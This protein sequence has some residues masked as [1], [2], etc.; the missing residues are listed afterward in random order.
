MRIR[1]SPGLWEIPPSSKGRFHT[2]PE[3][4]GDSTSPYLAEAIDEPADPPD[5]PDPAPEAEVGV[6]VGSGAAGAELAQIPT[7]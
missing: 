7:E 4:M 2:W 5:L 3:G 1:R 6:G